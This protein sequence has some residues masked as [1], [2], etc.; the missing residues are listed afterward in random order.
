MGLELRAATSR[1]TELLGRD[2]SERSVDP[3]VSVHSVSVSVQFGSVLFLTVFFR[4]LI[5]F[6]KKW[7]GLVDHYIAVTTHRIVIATE[8]Y[9]Y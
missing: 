7:K 1:V 9:H 2:R 4:T 3:F 5:M 8:W 6:G